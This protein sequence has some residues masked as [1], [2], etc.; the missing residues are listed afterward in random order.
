M[1]ASGEAPKSAS[2]ASLALRIAQGELTAE[3]AL[4]IFIAAKEEDE[5]SA[6]A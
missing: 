6:R 2:V 4:R 1:K 5:G 3:E